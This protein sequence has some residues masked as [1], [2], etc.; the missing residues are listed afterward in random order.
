MVVA[1]MHAGKSVH[2]RVCIPKFPCAAAQND[3]IV[4]RDRFR[5]A[6]CFPPPAVIFARHLLEQEYEG[7]SG[8]ALLY[9]QVTLWP[10]TISEP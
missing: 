5:G 9:G 3:R 8:D 6:K 2:I 7:I 4:L 1:F 10:V